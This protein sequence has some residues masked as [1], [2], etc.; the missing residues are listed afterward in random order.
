MD[1]F[2]NSHKTLKNTEI[3]ITVEKTI[4]GEYGDEYTV[5]VATKPDEIK[6]LLESG[7]EYVCQKDDLMFFRKRI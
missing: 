1:E 4:F 2:P 5:K 7:F 6:A 3:Y